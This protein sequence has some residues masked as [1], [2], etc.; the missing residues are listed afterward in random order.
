MMG[1]YFQKKL[2]DYT[3]ASTFLEKNNL[4]NIDIDEIVQK[5]NEWKNID[6]IKATANKKGIKKYHI[7]KQLKEILPLI[8]D[9]LRDKVQSDID[10]ID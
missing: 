7:V 4:G 1:I 6:G 3:R 9:S 5:Y 10:E 8:P 2:D